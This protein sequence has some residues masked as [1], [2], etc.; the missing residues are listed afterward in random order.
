MGHFHSG[1][2]PGE[3]IYLE[4]E[5]NKRYWTEKAINRAGFKVSKEKTIPLYP[6][7]VRK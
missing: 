3:H 7:S 6:S 4:G 5:G 2:I 1:V